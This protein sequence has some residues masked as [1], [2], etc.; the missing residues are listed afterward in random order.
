MTTFTENGL[1][2]L[3]ELERMNGDDLVYSLAR[4]R[5]QTFLMVVA[6]PSMTSRRW[7]LKDDE[8]RDEDGTRLMLHLDENDLNKD[9]NTLLHD[10]KEQIDYHTLTEDEDETDGN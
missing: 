8:K 3:L 9:Q 2:F 1:R 5:G 7:N 6:F 10:I 4:E